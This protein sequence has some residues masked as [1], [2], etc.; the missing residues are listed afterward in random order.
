MRFKGS[1]VIGDPSY[2]MKSDEDW[3][4]C[5]YGER[6]DLLGFTDFMCIDF[7]EDAQGVKEE[8][9]G[10]LLGGI[11]VDSGR[12][13][14]VYLEELKAYREDYEKA[15]YSKTNRAIIPD[16]DGEVSSEEVEDNEDDTYLSVYGTG[17]INFRSMYVPKKEL[18]TLHNS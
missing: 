17:N 12:V 5:E 18:Y 16:F 2:F 7:E 3:Q 13:V 15:F 4:K 14:V 10:Q 9:S 6:M 8:G 1:I 11:S